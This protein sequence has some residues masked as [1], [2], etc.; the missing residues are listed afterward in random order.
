MNMYVAS[1]LIAC[2]AGVHHQHVSFLMGIVNEHVCSS[3]LIA[4]IAGVHHQ[5]VS[6]LVHLLIEVVNC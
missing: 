6:F 2:I 5:H 3:E 1:E 4:C